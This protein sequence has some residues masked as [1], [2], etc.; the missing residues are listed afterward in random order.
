MELVKGG[1]VIGD[2]IVLV[3]ICFVVLVSVMVL[4]VGNGVICDSILV[5]VCFRESKFEVL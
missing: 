2:V 3:V 1:M 4:V 5:R